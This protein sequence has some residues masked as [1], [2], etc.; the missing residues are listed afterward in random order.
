M[1]ERLKLSIVIP[2]LNE[3]AN[4]S[5]A[6]A[7][8]WRLEPW[9]VIVCDGGSNDGT[10]H[11]AQQQGAQLIASSPGRGVQLN[12]GAGAATG[13]V[14]LFL[15]ADTWLEPI[16]AQQLDCALAD[17]RVEWGA[18]RQ[19]ID[20]PGWRYRALEW[21]NALRAKRWRLP[22]GDQAIFV[23]QSLFQD[24]G[25]FADHPVME[26]ADLSS[27]LR[28]IAPPALLSGPLHIS[29]RRWR[30]AGVVGQTL[31]NWAFLWLWKL[32]VSPHKLAKWY[33]PQSNA[34]GDPALPLPKQETAGGKHSPLQSEPR[35]CS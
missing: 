15:H 4:I 2:T 18:F 28:K 34:P 7:H 16:A 12:A 11:L 26:D 35:S 30:H 21:G 29:A 13:H 5:A 1:T 32:G 27:R 17:S 19:A 20:A 3:Q 9:E 24:L 8:A 14:L 6:I 25:G 31:R 10:P 23:R 22:Y 33:R